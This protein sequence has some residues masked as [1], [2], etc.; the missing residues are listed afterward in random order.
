MY[1]SSNFHISKQCNQNCFLQ[2]SGSH[3]LSHSFYCWCR[4]GGK[5]RKL[6]SDNLL[7][8]PAKWQLSKT[9]RNLLLRAWI[10]SKHL[11]A[12][13]MKNGSFP[14]LLKCSLGIWVFFAIFYTQPKD[15]DK[16]SLSL[17][18][19]VNYVMNTPVTS[20]SNLTFCCDGCRIWYLWQL[21]RG[22]TSIKKMIGLSGLLD[23]LMEMVSCSK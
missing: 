3:A 4:K 23:W 17:Q 13:L 22:S 2:Q 10:S 18:R 19:L 8:T 16:L 7:V 15:S 11:P 14:L 20:N 12:F 6:S 5:K 9:S 1:T 21:F